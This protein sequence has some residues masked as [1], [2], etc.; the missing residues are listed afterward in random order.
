VTIGVDRSR[1]LNTGQGWTERPNLAPGADPNP[2]LGGPDRYA[3]VSAFELQP[4]GFLGN[5]GRN[6]LIGPG[7]ATFDLTLA[8]HFPLGFG[9]SNAELRIAFFNL[10]NKANYGSPNTEAFASTD[11]P[12]PEFG[13]INSTSTT[14]RQGQIVLK[15]TF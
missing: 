4:A 1:N 11:G 3:D 10:F 13:R 8:K 6:T 7:M 2:V 12:N 15:V 9:S 14:P 5:L